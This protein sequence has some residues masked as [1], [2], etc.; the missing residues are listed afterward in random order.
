MSN[1][2]ILFFLYR[3]NDTSVA[4]HQQPETEKEFV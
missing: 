3:F 2:A 4:D 1:R